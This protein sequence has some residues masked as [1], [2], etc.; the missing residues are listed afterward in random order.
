MNKDKKALELA[1]LRKRQ[2]RLAKFMQHYANEMVELDGEICT[3]LT[4][5][6]PDAGLSPDVA[7]AAVAPKDPP[8]NG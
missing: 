4:E 1:K 8:P 6:A 7:A 3:L 5:C 2:A